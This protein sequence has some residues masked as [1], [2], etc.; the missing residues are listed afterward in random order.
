MPI[1]YALRV[2]LDELRRCKAAKDEAEFNCANNVKY[3]EN[4]R[5]F[6]EKIEQIDY[7]NAAIKLIRDDDSMIADP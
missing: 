2:L 5:I 1:N 7:L 3:G 6:T 4:L